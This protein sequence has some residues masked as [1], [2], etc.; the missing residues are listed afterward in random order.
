[1]M[2]AILLLAKGRMA[3]P[4]T[5]KELTPAAGNILR[6]F[7]LFIFQEMIERMNDQSV[8]LGV[9]CVS[10]ASFGCSA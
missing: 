9:F 5:T 7:L 10:A 2:R 1:M 3:W 8:S 4:F 6:K